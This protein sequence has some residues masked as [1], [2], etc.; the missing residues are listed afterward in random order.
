MSLKLPSRRHF[1]RISS[2]LAI[3][4]FLVP[5]WSSEHKYNKNEIKARDTLNG[6]S[7]IR[8][9]DFTSHDFSLDVWMN[10]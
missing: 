5:S 10:R 8:S 9:L 6:R 3:G 1:L 2:L 7:D 4:V